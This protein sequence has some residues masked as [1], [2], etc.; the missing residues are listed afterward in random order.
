MMPIQRSMRA[1]PHLAV[2]AACFA[3]FH[4]L[5]LPTWTTFDLK[6]RSSPGTTPGFNLPA[7]TSLYGQSVAL[8]A[9]GSLAIHVLREDDD[10][11]FVAP[12]GSATGSIVFATTVEQSD[13]VDLRGGILATASLFF[14]PGGAQT[15]NTSDGSLAQDFPAGGPE[16][17]TI[18]RGIRVLG[19]HA[20]A[21]RTTAGGVDKLLIDSFDS[22]AGRRQRVVASTGDAYSHLF[23]PATNDS[24]Q[25]AVAANLASGEAAVLRFDADGT[26]TTIAQTGTTWDGISSAVGINDAGMVAFF[27]RRSADQVFELL[28]SDGTTAPRRIAQ[29]G[30]LGTTDI[31]FTSAAPAIN[32]AGV[33]VF[34]ARDAAGDAIFAGDGTD[35]VRVIGDGDTITT[36]LGAKALGFDF[37]LTGREALSGGV[38]LNDANQLAFAAV[39]ENGTIALVR[40]DAASTPACQA[41]L[42]NNGDISDGLNPDGGIDIADFIAFLNLFEA[43]DTRGDLDDG[44]GAGL[45]DGG[46]D[47]ADFV[48]FLVHFEAG[49]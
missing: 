15:R 3:A 5:A 29:V 6:A 16:N 11:F 17:A 13:H 42:D 45:P 21:Y 36:D 14:P 34:R 18:V 25:M 49:C 43:G 30:D 38:A 40:A 48:F 31:G 28:V 2:V 46:V 8:D 37:P 33:V 27:A 20:I 26:P 7:G 35:L 32:A 23:I 47:I 41:D 12:P 9:D 24:R 1:S 4:A 44:S 10:A 39:L 19:A 22:E